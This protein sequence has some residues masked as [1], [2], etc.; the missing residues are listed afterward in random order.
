M[1]ERQLVAE[2]LSGKESAFTA[3]YRAYVGRVHAFAYRRT[4]SY[5]TA[6][7]ITA[8]TFERSTSWTTRSSPA[9]L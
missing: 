3:L 7:E 4:G 2:F 8:S 5:E 6:E 9:P 1:D